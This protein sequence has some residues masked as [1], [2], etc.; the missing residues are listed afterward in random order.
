MQIKAP[1]YGPLDPDE[2]HVEE[3]TVLYR[4]D[5]GIMIVYKR[6]HQTVAP[7][8]W[9]MFQSF[10]NASMLWDPISNRY[11]SPPRQRRSNFVKPGP[12]IV[13]LDEREAELPRLR[14]LLQREIRPG[15]DRVARFMHGMLQ[16]SEALDTPV[17]H[18]SL[19]DQLL[20]QLT[21]SRALESQLRAH[22]G[23][24]SITLDLKGMATMYL[25]AL[26]RFS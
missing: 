12:G 16:G 17:P 11:P 6:F 13:L 14:A 20:P 4:F 1:V 5:R 3:I 8:D 19:M 10:V 9:A 2:F 18:M 22:Y 23:E 25:R 26:G 7:Q 15:D 21:E 24:L